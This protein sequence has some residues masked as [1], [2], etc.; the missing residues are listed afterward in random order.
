MNFLNLLKSADLETKVFMLISVLVL[1]I[2]QAIIFRYKW[3]IPLTVI[4]YS[5]FGLLLWKISHYNL[6]VHLV[7]YVLPSFFIGQILWLLY[8]KK[9]VYEG[10][11][12]FYYQTDNGTIKIYNI[13][14]G[15][16]IFGGPGSG[17]TESIIKP[18]IKN[19]A[20]YGFCGVIYDYKKFQLTK[21][22]Y[23]QYKDV[24][25]IQFRMINFFDLPFTYR[26]NPISPKLLES[27]AY[28]MEA[29]NVLMTNLSPS[30]YK[31]DKEKFWVETP[32]GILAGIFWRL[33][34]DFPE[35][36]YLPYAIA[37]C[38][39]KSPKQLAEFLKG[40]KISQ[41]LAAS[42]L[43]GSEA[44]K[45]TA[46]VLATLSNALRRIAI[47]EIT[48]VLMGDDFSLNLNNT[49]RPTLLCISNIQKLQASY[50]PVISLIVSMALKQMSDENKHP[51]AV[52]LDEGTTLI[53]PG[54]DNIPNTARSNKVASIFC[55][56]D[57]VQ[58]EDAYGRIG[59]DKIL[60][61][62][63]NMFFGKVTDPDTAEWYSKVYGTFEKKFQSYTR[64]FGEFGASSYNESVREVT[65]YKPNEFINLEPGHFFGVI[66]DGN[67]KEFKGKFSLIDEPLLS[68]PIVRDI[69]KNEVDSLFD[70]VLNEAHNI[71]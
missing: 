26:I 50:S 21:Y 18:T 29:A 42:F 33:K 47:P 37:I 41:L 13:F 1:S 31:G 57:K 32:E 11:Y 68:L 28:A 48:Y 25:D 23:T 65:R 8:K 40:N 67:K 16:A 38:L 49:E 70:N 61:G 10:E 51:S 2:L 19:M 27:P 17:K 55:I 22:A 30:S 45:Q 71:F 35:K 7:F 62:L 20:K 64:K 58:G 5:L 60:A 53:I 44:E 56:Q 52:L 4:L 6:I 12:P 43:Q 59:R 36:C 15:L 54:F 34:E 63:S 46:G 24:P 9:K 3:R 69:T 14:R 66:A 39:Q